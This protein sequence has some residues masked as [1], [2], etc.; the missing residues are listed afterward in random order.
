MRRLNV[1]T[2][3]IRFTIKDVNGCFTQFWWTALEQQKSSP[4]SETEFSMNLHR[5]TTSVTI[6]QPQT[7]M[8]AYTDINCTKLFHC[9][10]E[11][12]NFII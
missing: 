3:I 10:T 12:V 6:P 5:P 2:Y 9:I 11:T 1:N 4:K 7:K 8:F